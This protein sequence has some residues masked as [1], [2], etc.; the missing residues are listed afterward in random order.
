MSRGVLRSRA[1]LLAMIMLLVA[2]YVTLVK[3]P[4]AGEQFIPTLDA[5]DVPA[6]WKAVDTEVVDGGFLIQERATRYYFVDADPV[7]TLPLAKEVAEKAGFV[8]R[9]RVL[10]INGCEDG[11]PPEAMDGPCGPVIADDCRSNGGLP[12]DCVVE[13]L[14]WDGESVRVERLWI[15]LQPRGTGFDVGQGENRR[16][17]SDPDLA[18]VW[19]TVNRVSRDAYLPLP[20]WPPLE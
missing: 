19:I 17:I 12:I 1:V 8:V 7:E 20:S 16:Y 9:P 15:N 10:S 2:A 3:W 14:R 5:L 11:F 6:S 13:A 18:S 4:H